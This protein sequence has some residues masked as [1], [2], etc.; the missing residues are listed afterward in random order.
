MLDWGRKCDQFKCFILV[1]FFFVLGLGVLVDQVQFGDFF[2]LLCQ[3]VGVIDM[4]EG[5]EVEYFVVIV[6]YFFVEIGD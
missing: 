5:G 2:V 6:Y 4:Q 1:V 3:V